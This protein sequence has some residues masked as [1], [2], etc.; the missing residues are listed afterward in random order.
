MLNVYSI[1]HDHNSYIRQLRTIPDVL[2]TDGACERMQRQLKWHRVIMTLAV[3]VFLSG[4][5]ASVLQ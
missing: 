2:Q 5:A 3:A 1:M 4:I